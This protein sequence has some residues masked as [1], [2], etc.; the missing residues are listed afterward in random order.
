[1]KGCALVLV[2]CAS[3]LVGL[4]VDAAHAQQPNPNCD[5]FVQLTGERLDDHF[6]DYIESSRA[7]EASMRT[8][9]ITARETRSRRLLNRAYRSSKR[10]ER[11]DALGTTITLGQI[12]ESYRQ[13]APGAGCDPNALVGHHGSLVTQVGINHARRMR[14]LRK[15]YERTVR[16]LR[17]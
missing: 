11:E 17:S 6:A 1:M 14:R 7:I 9:A 3:L 16:A 15:I 4:P 13:R 5:L 12:H 8:Q 2:V 10:A